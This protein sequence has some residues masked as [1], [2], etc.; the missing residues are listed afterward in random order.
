MFEM[1]KHSSKLFFAGKLFQD[2]KLV[3]RQLAIGA[4][5]GAV[6]LIVVGQFAP[7]WVAAILGGAVAGFLQPILFKDLKYA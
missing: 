3:M 5:A 1:V 7:V 6:V 4:G 2:N